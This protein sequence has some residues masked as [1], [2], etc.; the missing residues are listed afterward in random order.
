MFPKIL[1]PGLLFLL[2][3]SALGW[4]MSR[5]LAHQPLQ[6]VPSLQVARY[7]GTWYE[8]AAIPM[9]FQRNCVGS[10]KAE[11]TLLSD[12]SIKVLNSCQTKSGKRIQAEGR[13]RIVD[14]KTNA[15]L[16]VTFAHWGNWWWYGVSG[17]YWVIALDEEAYQYAVVGHPR[18]KYGWILS[19]TEA[20]APA[21]LESLRQTL[22]RQGYDP[23]RFQIT[24]QP[25]G[26]SEKRPLC[27]SPMLA[28][29][30]VSQP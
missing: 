27:K 4:G 25:G 19:R 12:G 14:T 3:V 23:C 17:D 5:D 21:V 15:R 6:V 20:M 7:Q 2:L 8:I 18:R 29:G 1:I 13:A 10:T 11:Y 30:R 26:S 28:P 16:Q 24:P 9:F 22:V